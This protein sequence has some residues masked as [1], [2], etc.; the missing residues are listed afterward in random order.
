MSLKISYSLQVIAIVYLFLQN[1]IK[2]QFEKYSEITQQ[3]LHQSS[4]RALSDLKW[5]DD[6]VKRRVCRI[7]SHLE[8]YFEHEAQ[9]KAQLQAENPPEQTKS[10]EA[11]SRQSSVLQAPTTDTHGSKRSQK[12]S[13][14]LTRSNVSVSTTASSRRARA[15]IDAELAKQKLEQQ[16]EIQRIKLE[17]VRAEEEFEKIRWE[18]EQKQREAERKQLELKMKED[19]MRV[20]NEARAKQLEVDLWEEESVRERLGSDYEEDKVERKDLTDPLFC[21]SKFVSDDASDCGLFTNAIASQGNECC[22]QTVMPGLN[23]QAAPFVPHLLRNRD[24]PVLHEHEQNPH[25]SR[26]TSN[27]ATALDGSLNALSQAIIQTQLPKREIAVFDGNPRQYQT[28]ITNFQANVSNKFED[29]VT[30]LTYL[31][32]Y[33]SGKARDVIDDCILLPEKLCFTTALS[34]LKERFGTPYLIA[35]SYIESLLKGPEIKSNDVDGLVNLADEMIKCQSVL[36]Q[37]QFQSNLD[38]NDTLKQVAHRLPNSLYAKWVDVASHIL[39]HDRQP[40]FKDLTDFIKSKART[41]STLFGRDYASVSQTRFLKGK[42]LQTTRHMKQTT[43]ATQVDTVKGIQKGHFDASSSVH[44]LNYQGSSTFQSKKSVEKWCYSC[45]LSNHNTTDCGKLKKKTWEENVRLF[46]DMRLCFCCA[47][48]GHLARNCDALCEKCRGHHHVLVHDENRHQRKDAKP[49]E[50]I[51]PKEQ[52]EVRVNTALSKST[53]NE[54]VAMPVVPAIISGGQCQIQTYALIDSGCDISVIRRDIFDKLGLHGESLSY[55][56]KTMSSS[57]EI[58]KQYKTTLSLHSLDKETTVKAQAITVD[59]MPIDANSLFDHKDLHAWDHLKDFDLPRINSKSVGMIIGSNV[60]EASWTLEERRGL[61]TAR[62]TVFGWIIV[63]PY[64]TTQNREFQ[65]NWATVDQ[66]QEQLERQWQFDFNDP[67]KNSHRSMS[68][69]DREAL[70][71]MQKS[72]QLKDGKYQ[73]EIPWKYDPANLPDNKYS[74]EIRLTSLKRKLEKDEKLHEKYTA[75]V[76][77]YVSDGHA[78]MMSKEEA[79]AKGWYLPHHPVFKKSNPSKCRVVFDCAARYQGVSL[80]DAILQGPNLLNSLS[81]VLTRFRSQPVAVIADIEA[82]FHQCFVTRQ[83]QDYLRFLWWPDGDLRKD[84]KTYTMMVHLFGA[85]SSPSVANFCV[86]KTAEDNK[87]LYEEEVIDSVL[88]SLYM[89][90]LLRS[91]SSEE[92]A[93]NLVTDV[94]ALLKKGGFRLT[95]WVSNSRAVLAKIPEEERGKS[96]ENID[97]LKDQLPEN[98]TLGLQWNT[99]EDSFVYN[100]TLPAKPKTRRGLLSLTASLFDPLGFVCPV[101]LIPKKLQQRL[102]KENFEWD[103]IMPDHFAAEISSWRNNLHCL[104]QIRVPRCFKSKKQ[105]QRE[106]IELHL[107]SDASETGYGAA[108]Y[109]KIQSDSDCDVSLVMGKSRVTP[110]KPITIPRLELTAVVVSVKL[111][112][113]IV[114]EL[115]LKIDKSYFWTDS[116]VV[117]RYLRNTSSRFKTFVANRIE[118]IQELSE[119]QDWH[120]VP[121][122]MNP[123]D[124][125]SRGIEPHETTKLKFWLNGPSYLKNSEYPNFHQTAQANTQDLEIRRVLVCEMRERDCSYLLQY[126]S[127]F[128]KLLRSVIWFRRFI[129]YLQWKGNNN[130]TL[131]TGGVTLTEHV[132]AEQ[133]IILLVQREEFREELKAVKCGGIVKTSSRLSTL[134][135]VIMSDL[136]RVGGRQPGKHPIIL[137]RHHVTDLIIRQT[138]EMNGHVGVNHCRSILSERFFILQAYSNIKRCVTSCFQCKVQNKQPMK[139]QMAP[140]PPVRIH[141]GDPPFTNIGIDYF[142]P[143]QVKRSRSTT[144]RWGCLFTCLATRAVHI[145]IAY[146]LSAGSFLLDFHRF[147]A[148]CGKPAL[149]WSDN[150]TNF[151]AAERD[152]KKELTKIN[153]RKIEE[154]M[155]VEAI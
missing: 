82:M 9:S 154:D 83:D 6:E 12:K 18:A 146:P 19:Y 116:Q 30:R 37:L 34:R 102:C 136:L 76:E 89:D 64:Q 141:S 29:E 52:E 111:H 106:R 80:N 123:A 88:R 45:K 126:F 8:I 2:I 65:V 137:P 10:P 1:E 68:I 109:L 110:L 87:E 96:L 27:Q 94:S 32:Q 67:P 50:Q 28:F 14:C 46:K 138:H 40:C 131:I 105:E 85:T 100:V 151:T 118:I 129:E 61:P 112:Q 49:E 57:K 133:R 117:I 48:R 143:F 121:S 77:K 92:Q 132:D 60:V 41:A 75:T 124:L 51:K 55:T 42:P 150:G 101:T 23:E 59:E 90:D 44:R 95:K 15:R 47:E 7:L 11:R 99:E 26:P 108:A 33:C 107:F 119:V 70:H 142:G 35:E 79:D 86:R 54:K 17:Q 120:Y 97:I 20:Q 148:R 114:E 63:G 38:S 36:A 84:P 22:T 127:D 25:Q 21:A 149:V 73:L 152:L 113:F 125:S 66:L 140:L 135:P 72:C 139:Q 31:L 81:G 56:M 155:M 153:R 134:C 93:A 69:E 74:A 58:E 98:S 91:T 16:Q 130:L 3:C 115:D 53:G 71:I 104:S 39:S 43:L 147:M 103:D 128:K 13:R 24:N 62:R 4:E 5:N 145:E 122:S 78:R 144:K